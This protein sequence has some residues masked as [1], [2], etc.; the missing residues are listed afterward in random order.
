MTDARLE[1]HFEGPDAQSQAQELAGLL[2]REL[3]DWPAELVERPA[4]PTAETAMRSV[5]LIKV[6]ALILSIPGAINSTLTLADRIKLKDKLRRLVEWAGARRQR[7]QFVP[8][9]VSPSGRS[10]PLD[11]DRVYQFLDELAGPGA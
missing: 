3:P 6:L 5:E 11:D 4:S 10:L 2:E 8:Q 1:F 7:N 9:L